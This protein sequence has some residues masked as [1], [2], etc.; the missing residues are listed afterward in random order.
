VTHSIVR[1]LVLAG[2]VLLLAPFAAGCGKSTESTGPVPG[3]AGGVN[4]LVYRTDRSGPAGQFDIAIFDLDEGGY[5]SVENLNSSADESEPCLS[6]DGSL[7]TF[8]S[9]RA[10]G[11]GGSDVY[12]YDRATAQIVAAPGLNS[13][14]NETCPRFAYDSVY[15]LFVRDSSGYGRVRTYDPTGDTL[16]GMP[17]LAAEGPYTDT[18][19]ATDLHAHRVAFQT[20]RDGSWDVRVWNQVGGLATLPDLAAAGSD[21]VEPSLSADGRWLAFA[22]DRPGGAGGFDIYLY[23]LVN[24]TFIA[25]PGLNT[26]GEERHPAV[27]VAG[28]VLFFQARPTPADHWNLYQYS[29]TTHALTQP[30]G[31]PVAADRM[32]P[33]A[34]VR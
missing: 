1:S 27:N 15:L 32:Q 19:P 17:G 29:I 25:L 31:A 30:V 26:A 33:Y 12:V 10:G 7:V 13:A 21:D 23:D 8:A 24:S 4:L 9:D 6:N 3:D 5:R 34:R 16:I 14:A 28:T 18:A 11:S 2:M 20:N 22:S